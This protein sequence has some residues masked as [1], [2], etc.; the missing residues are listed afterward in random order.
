[1]KIKILKLKRKDLQKKRGKFDI[2]AKDLFVL[3][4]KLNKLGFVF[5]DNCIRDENCFE[6]TKDC[7]DKRITRFLQI[8]KNK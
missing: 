8:W 2:V 3:W 1:M 4:D 7:R 5:T 6:E